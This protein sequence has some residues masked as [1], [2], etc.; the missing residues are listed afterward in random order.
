MSLLL[1]RD[2]FLIFIVFFSFSLHAETFSSVGTYLFPTNISEEE[3]FDRAKNDAVKKVMEMAGFSVKV[4]D[5]DINN[6]KIT[7]NFDWEIFKVIEE[8]H[9]L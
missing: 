5:G 4:I 2:S 9:N 6:F 1:L 8:K 3:C 7:N